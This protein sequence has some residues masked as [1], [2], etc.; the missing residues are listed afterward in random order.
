MIE[1]KSIEGED[2][3]GYSVPFGTFTWTRW[4]EMQAQTIQYF[5][6][7]QRA[8][9]HERIQEATEIALEMHEIALEWLKEACSWIRE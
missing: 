5:S 6:R 3:A 1:K 8:I 7:F 4:L 2:D 9:E